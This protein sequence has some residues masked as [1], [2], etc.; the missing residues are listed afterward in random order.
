[1]RDC[2]KRYY[3]DAGVTFIF[4]SIIRD[5]LVYTKQTAERACTII[6]ISANQARSDA[7]SDKSDQ[8]VH[9]TDVSDGRV[10]TQPSEINRFDNF[11]RR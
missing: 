10:N 6:I 4:F 2:D 11:S 1:M 7:L 3:L 9:S 8:F 5:I